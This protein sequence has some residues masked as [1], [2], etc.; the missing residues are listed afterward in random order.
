MQGKLDGAYR[1]S[2]REQPQVLGAGSL[3]NRDF[4]GP[5]STILPAD[6]IDKGSNAFGRV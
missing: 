2:A 4:T 6:A 5:A 1:L 3:R